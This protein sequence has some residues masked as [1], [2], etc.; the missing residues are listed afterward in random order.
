MGPFAVA[1][2]F[3]AFVAIAAVAGIVADY[4]KRQAALA[5]LHAAI[6]R[7]QQLD[8]ALVERLMTP[9]RDNGVNPI[10]LRIGGIIVLWIGVGIV[11]LAFLLA[12]IAPDALYPVLGGGALVLCLGTGLLLS[13]R[14]V[15]RSRQ[16]VA[17]KPRNGAQ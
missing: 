12:Q 9:E 4:K 1:I 8:P 15:E 5:P 6:E 2:A 10:Y 13:A 16:A 17:D 11:I 3:W 14:A 7:G